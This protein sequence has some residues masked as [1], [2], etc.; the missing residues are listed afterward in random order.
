MRF[1]L[2]TQKV[3]RTLEI[4]VYMKYSV[5]GYQKFEPGAGSP[6][7]PSRLVEPGLEPPET[8][9]LLE[10]SMRNLSLLTPALLIV[11]LLAAPMPA[12]AHQQ[13]ASHAASPSSTVEAGPEETA[14]DSPAHHG[15]ALPARQGTIAGLVTS[16]GSERPLAAAQV[17]IVGAQQGGLT[18]ADGRYSISGVPAGDVT[19]E[20]RL[21][22][23][24]RERADVT[25]RSG[26][27]TTVDFELRSEAI[28]LDEMVVTG[29]AGGAERRAIG[30]A[31]TRLEVAR[32]V[33]LAP[34][35]DV[36]SLL[37]ARA[38]G[39]N[40]T[41]G[42]GMVGAGQRLRIRGA[43]S[44]SLSD[45]PLIYID[46][47]RV[48]NRV[49]TGP[50]VDGF[51]SGMVSR[52]N[53]IDASDIESIE[54]IKGPAAATLYGTEASNGVIQIMTKRGQAGQAEFTARIR[55]G[56]TWFHNAE[57]RWHTNYRP[58]PTTG[59]LLG[60]NIVESER[61]N[62]TPLFKA[63]HL[64]SYGLDVRG[65]TGLIQ[66]FGSINRTSDNG[67]EPVNSL[68]RTNARMNLTLTPNSEWEVQGS[69]GITSGRTNLARV[70][71]GIWF[72][73]VY[74]NP[75][76]TLDGDPRR[77]FWNRPP[78]ITYEAFEDY[79][80][81][82]RFNTALNI[83][84]RPAGWFSHRLNVGFDFTHDDNSTIIPRMRPEVAQF[85]SE[86]FARGQ[87][88]IHVQNANY[89]TWDYGGTL[90]YDVTDRIRSNSSFGFQY[91]NRKIEDI[92]SRGNEFPS[93]G[94]TAVNAT[95]ETFGGSNFEENATVGLY[96]QEQLSLDDR[97]FLT[98]AI[99]V[100]DNSA[101][102]EEFEL[103]YYPKASFSWVV[104]EQDFW[105][106]DFLNTLRVRGAFGAT[107]QQPE[108]F[109]A[110]RT[111]M[112]VTAGD[113][114]PAAT[115]EFIGNP[116]LAPERGEEFEL[117]FEAAMLD[118]RLGLDF[119]FY[120]QTTRDAI[121]LRSQPPSLGFPESQFVNA[122]SI[123][124]RGIE[125]QANLQAHTAPG[126]SWEVGLGLS[127]HANE[128]LD[129]GDED[130]IPLGMQQH[131]VGYPV[132]A[133]FE[134]EVVDATLD[135]DGIARN[136]MCAG[137][138]ENDHQAV[139]CADA[140]R[141]F[142]GRPEPNLELSLRNTW[143]LFDQVTV[144]ALLDGAFGHKKHNGHR[145]VRCQ[146]LRYC[147][148]NYFP[149][150]Y[151]PALIAEI[152]STDPRYRSF[153]IEDA[154]FVKLREVSV[155]FQVPTGWTQAIGANRATVNLGARNLFTWTKW[156]ALDPEAT[157]MGPLHNRH[158]QEQM[159]QLQEFVTRINLTF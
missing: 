84:H 4:V 77:G 55:Q 65:G 33:E 129:L 66:Y 18:S 1:C 138:P 27:T 6:S 71:G 134:F 118:Q 151:D 136:L 24:A 119:T 40:V 107:G 114:S 41:M 52:F 115:P 113:G 96:V 49:A 117:G 29:T 157:R 67:I 9:P 25:V 99:R 53:D 88:S 110:L 102:G 97:L 21:L 111:Y 95:A 80:E 30:N 132:A 10:D 140:P 141:V 36:G 22:G 2:R 145:R 153:Y 11:A 90:H 38:P 108:T 39:V 94:L 45:Q 75:L 43:S 93:R 158:E 131:R 70:N 103:V 146:E 13:A 85:F 130:V 7:F 57:D 16:Q 76:H 120:N 48:D 83:N 5:L 106:I 104:S 14:R 126:W 73:S 15:A 125:L 144:F 149:E 74:A 105:D 152:Q 50:G 159:P 155:S 156:D 35:S 72:A 100:D 79:Q 8:T 123:R 91:Y 17:S 121:L 68:R 20:V 62:G 28:S 19:V 133:W 109:A 127:R 87:R 58:H 147:L 154:S 116:E 82:R 42:S 31:V 69:L 135:Q 61:L 86:T 63:G 23:Y 46:G 78:E 47:V 60:I 54:V 44:F 92:T 128:I 101:F 51:G 37:R 32:E 89:L 139:P 150:D 81:T 59:E 98:A 26:Q 137:G 3:I 64:Q 112:P 148:E 12:G 122:G 142:Q 56:V 34:I 124:N 143:T